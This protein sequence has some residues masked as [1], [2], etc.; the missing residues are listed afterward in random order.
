[1]LLGSAKVDDGSCTRWVDDVLA[2]MD[3]GRPEVLLIHTSRAYAVAGDIR[4]ADGA[5][6]RTDDAARTAFVAGEERMI[7]TATA[8]GARVVLV[9]GVP[10]YPE[11]QI[12]RVALVRPVAH[13]QAQRVDDFL[14]DTAPLDTALTAMASS[15]GA[16]A[17]ATWPLLCGTQVCS[18]RDDQGQW[19][20]RDWHHLTL[21]GA[22]RLDGA[23]TEA[24]RSALG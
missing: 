24:V 20:Y 3:T 7:Q 14:A 8:L 23:L 6:A 13:P 19:I 21:R 15:A 2:W 11:S 16:T 1:V 5:V 4:D 12:E 18:Q 9:E 17:V 22:A 10:T